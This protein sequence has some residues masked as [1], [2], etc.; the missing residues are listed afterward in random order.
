MELQ[1]YKLINSH[2]SQI[3]SNHLLLI[4]HWLISKTYWASDF[5]LYDGHCSVLHGSIWI[6]S[7]IFRFESNRIHASGIRVFFIQKEWIQ[8]SSKM[9]SIQSL[10]D[11]DSLYMSQSWRDSEVFAIS[12][13][14][15]VL[16]QQ[17]FGFSVSHAS[18]LKTRKNIIK[19]RIKIIVQIVILIDFFIY[20][21]LIY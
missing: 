17:I 7:T 1:G 21:K 8:F 14:K 5:G 2:L 16:L 6:I 15:H 18:Y 4:N 20:G 3:W 10:S 13:L 9:K 19:N 11:K 12:R